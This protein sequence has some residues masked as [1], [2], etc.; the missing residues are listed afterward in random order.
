M[1]MM[2]ELRTQQE[3]ADFITARYAGLTG[4]VEA[5]STYY[6]RAH[7]TSPNDSS[8][9]EFAVLSTL[10]VGS[11]EEAIKVARAARGPV[12]EDSATAQIALA[13]DD[14]ASNRLRQAQARMR[15][16]ALGA[17]NI[18]LSSFLADRG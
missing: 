16:P 14:I 10:I 18:D 9:L 6:R 7:S 5:A 2:E 12:A 3:Y 1:A 4:D 17:L 8:L 13:V 15:N 11:S